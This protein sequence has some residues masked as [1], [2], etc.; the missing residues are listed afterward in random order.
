MGVRSGEQREHGSGG[1]A[2]PVGARSS[3]KRL[4]EQRKDD[5]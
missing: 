2:D 1:E 5:V 3:V 4:S